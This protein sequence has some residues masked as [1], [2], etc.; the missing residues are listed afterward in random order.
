MSK[1]K[2]ISKSRAV[3]S[4]NLKPSVVKLSE[5]KQIRN[6]KNWKI[7]YSSCDDPTASQSFIINIKEREYRIQDHLWIFDWTYENAQIYKTE[8]NVGA[9]KY[10][11][12]GLDTKCDPDY[13]GSS[14]VIHHYG[15]VYG[16]KP[17]FTKTVLKQLEHI[18]M[19][20]LCSM[21][22]ECI[23]KSKEESKKAG[24]H[25]INYTG[26]NRRDSGPQIDVAKV[27]AEVISEAKKLGLK[28]YMTTTTLLLKPIA[29]PPPFDKASGSGMHIE[30]SAGLNKIGFCFLKH[31]GSHNNIGM[32]KRI[33][34]ELE[35][36]KDS[37]HQSGSDSD[38]QYFM[39]FHKSQDPVH[40]AGLYKRLVDKVWEHSKLFS[41]EPMDH[42][43]PLPIKDILQQCNVKLSTGNFTIMQYKGNYIRIHKEGSK[44]PESNS[45][46]VL[47]AVDNEYS[48]RIADKDW[49]QT[50]RAGNA[51]LVKLNKNKPR[52]I[53]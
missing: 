44:L 8:F 36:D 7:T 38:Y 53:R 34:N 10:I 27:G 42:N 40:I 15:E 48:L 46:E 37:I 2:S 20:Q 17:F 35:F 51:V 1:K 11:Y 30:T 22:Q 13:F 18:T 4:L 21:E 3:P 25:S 12:V 14:L 50:Q 28:L 45:K 5:I 9:K 49:A 6:S 43:K 47:R 52:R 39:V 41:N 23:K 29:P 19:T 24:T 33:F 16:T 32:A 26:A 31:R